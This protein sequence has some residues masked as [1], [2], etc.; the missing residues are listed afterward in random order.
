MGKTW[1]M[2]IPPHSDYYDEGLY[3][4]DIIS[5]T[6]R[7]GKS[8]V[9]IYKDIYP[10]ILTISDTMKNAVLNF[11]ENKIIRK[12]FIFDDP[13]EPIMTKKEKLKSIFNGI[14]KI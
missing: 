2:Y 14:E 10:P 3:I 13:Q 1:K 12:S 4:K 7:S 5:Y 8:I 11:Y 9:Y 6:K